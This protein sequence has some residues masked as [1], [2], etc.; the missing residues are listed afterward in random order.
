MLMKQELD[1]V[2]KA[3]VLLESMGCTSIIEV[4]DE[5]GKSSVIGSY[6]E[7]LLTGEVVEFKLTVP[8]SAYNLESVTVHVFSLEGIL[9]GQNTRQF[10]FMEG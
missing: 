5:S 9:L 3:K 2:S 1:T 4:F 7:E 10:D 8:V 6:T